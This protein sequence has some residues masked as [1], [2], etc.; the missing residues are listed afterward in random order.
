MAH[1]AA[2]AVGVVLLVM[3]AGCSQEAPSSGPSRAPGPADA[4]FEAALGFSAD[5]AAQADLRMEESVAGCMSEQ[6]FE[7]VPDTSMYHFVDAAEIDP[8]P[9]TR[10]FAEQFGYGFAA[11]PE[12][13]SFESDGAPNANDV[14]M[15]AMSPE[16]LEAY[17]SALWGD[18]VDET[19]GE[20]ELGGCYGA[21]RDEVW[22]DP[23]EDPVRV[24]L[25][26]EIARIDTEVTPMDPDV[27]EA[28]AQWSTCMSD[29]GHPGYA[30]PPDAEQ[31]AG[32]R[33][34]AFN[35]AIAADPTLG[36]VGPDGGVV[37]EAD[38]AAVEAAVA[39]ADWDC[40]EDSGYDAVWQQARDR[41]QQ[42]YVDGHR[43][44]LEAWVE[45]FS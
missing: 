11:L 22:G 20:A 13:M 10:E 30:E 2:A 34:T 6:G 4:Y 25:E 18:T 26:E 31:A 8:P 17:S 7:Y 36:A 43:S 3:A 15:G 1:R 12:G 33:W 29:A 28:A 16:E 40:R 5:D 24:A 41:F 35:D 42:E 27:L 19:T 44:E 38:L 39:T 14:I 21:A 23:D 37:G 32:D 45:S 9:G